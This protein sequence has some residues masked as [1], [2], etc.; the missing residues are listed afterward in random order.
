VSLG[1]AVRLGVR[2]RRARSARAISKELRGWRIA[3]GERGV[4]IVD[5]G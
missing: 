5:C 4:E 3:D 2:D 1:E